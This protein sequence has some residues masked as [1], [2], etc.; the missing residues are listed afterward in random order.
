MKKYMIS[1]CIVLLATGCSFV[2]LDS[3][4]RDITVLEDANLVKDCKSLG[5]TNVSL[6]SKAE[7]FQSRTK[8]ESQFDTLAR[9]QAATMGGNTVVP[10]SQTIKGQRKYS[11]YNCALNKKQ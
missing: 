7:T 8:V 2:S 10:H 3:Q 9:N 5:D 11:V 1:L 4:A 6:W